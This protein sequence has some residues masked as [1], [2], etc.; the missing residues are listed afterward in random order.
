MARRSF[1]TPYPLL[2]LKSNSFTTFLNNF[3]FLLINTKVDKHM[4]PI[5]QREN[6]IDEAL[7]NIRTL[8]NGHQE[9]LGKSFIF[10][11]TV[12][13]VKEQQFWKYI[14]FFCLRGILVCI[15]HKQMFRKWIRKVRGSVES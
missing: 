15:I 3:T 7:R 6:S 4:L 5:T 1:R 14:Y 12:V 13:Y 2:K 9:N 11:F 8:E 10:Y